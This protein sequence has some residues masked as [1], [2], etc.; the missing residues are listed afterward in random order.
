MRVNGEENKVVT[1]ARAPHDEDAV[2]DAEIE[3][4]GSAEEG[5]ETEAE[6]EE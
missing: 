6:T 4:D 3:D 2:D 5:A 1:L